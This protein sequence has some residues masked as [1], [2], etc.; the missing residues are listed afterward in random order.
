MLYEFI[1]GKNNFLEMIK[2]SE[3]AFL[4]LL[5][6][7]FGGVYYVNKKRQIEFWNKEAERITGYRKE[8]VVGKYCYDNILQHI[9]DENNNL[10]KN[11]C[12]LQATIED[13]KRRKAEVYLHHKEGQRVPVLVK[14]VP[15]RGEKGEITGAVELFLKN[16][17]RKSLEEKLLELKKE[18]FKDRLTDINNRKYLE[19]ILKELLNSRKIKKRNIA[20][21]FLDIDDFK[22]IN[23]NFGHTMG[24]RILKMVANTLKDN[25]RPSDQVFRWGGDEFALI[26]F[27]VDNKRALNKLLNRI[28]VLIGNS[29]INH[30]NKK[31]K[32]TI[33]VGATLLKENDDIDTLTKRAD[34]NMYNSKEAGKNLI[35]IS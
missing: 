24:D 4:K 2:M 14:V 6:N 27:D 22:D 9:D 34:Q 21:G 29:F 28:K 5:D 12:P 7:I 10:C 23:D 31:I 19:E 30:Q 15:I 33:S 18:N 17:Q 13:G 35:T 1:L 20:F 32:V 8:E 3:Q 11:G 26:L 16:E 25:V